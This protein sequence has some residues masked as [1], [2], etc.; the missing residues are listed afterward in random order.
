M[1]NSFQSVALKHQRKI[2]YATL[3]MSDAGAV[4]MGGMTKQEARKILAGA[5]VEKANKIAKTHFPNIQFSV[6]K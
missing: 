2:A 1:S 5:I 4:I 6:K 3:K